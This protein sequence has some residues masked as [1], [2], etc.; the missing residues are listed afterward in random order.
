M[1]VR[2]TGRHSAKLGRIVL[3]KER[4][5]M[6][7]RVIVHLSSLRHLLGCTTPAVRIPKLQEYAIGTVHG[8]SKIREALLLYP[9]R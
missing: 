3:K 6:L 8:Q 9:R 4:L 1:G 5:A 7:Y 2:E